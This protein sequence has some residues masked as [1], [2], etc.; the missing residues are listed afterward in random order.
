MLNSFVNTMYYFGIVALPFIA[1][2][3]IP[4]AIEDAKFRKRHR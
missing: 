1:C 3:I 2:F 4:W